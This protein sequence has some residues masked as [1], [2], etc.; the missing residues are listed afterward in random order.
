MLGSGRAVACV[1]VVAWLGVA[2]V[3]SAQEPQDLVVQS[4]T[5]VRDSG[6]LEQVIVPDFQRR[7]PAVAAEGR[8][9]R[10]RSGDHQRA[11]RARATC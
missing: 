11:R 2:A 9:G 6:L 8:R 5:S 1:L 4:T 3:A 10:H 7:V